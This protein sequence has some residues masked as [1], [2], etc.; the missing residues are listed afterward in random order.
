MRSCHF[1]K[2]NQNQNQTSFT[3]SYWDTIWA[4]HGTSMA[5]NEGHGT[6]AGGGEVWL[7]IDGVQSQL[8]K[9]KMS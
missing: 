3:A 5:W 9:V 4:I 2:L 7:E 6:Q 1:N 8:Y